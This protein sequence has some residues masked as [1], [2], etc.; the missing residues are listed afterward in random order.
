MLPERADHLATGRGVMRRYTWAL[1]VICCAATLAPV[2]FA[3]D[4]ASPALVAL[5]GLI[6][7]NDEQ[8][9]PIRRARVWAAW[10]DGRADPVFTDDRGRFEIVVRRSGGYSLSVSKPGFA[11]STE[12]REAVDTAEPI[13]IRLTRGAVISGTVRDGNGK[14]V[15]GTGIVVRRTDPSG[16]TYSSGE[17][18]T[19]TDD[20]GEFRVGSLAAGPYA[21][22]VTRPGSQG[23]AGWRSGIFVNAAVDPNLVVHARAGEEQTVHRVFDRPDS[24][25]AGA[26]S[27]VAGFVAGS[28]DPGTPTTAKGGSIAGRVIDAD[29][30]PV[31]AAIVGAF[32]LS[33]ASTH[34]FVEGTFVGTTRTAAASDA[35]GR[36][37]LSGLQPDTYRIVARP[38][39]GRL[40]IPTEGAGAIVTL[41]D[42]ERA[43][44]LDVT[45]PR[46][47]AIAGTVVD[48]FGD[49]IE[50]I[51]VQAW[52]ARWKEGRHVI[53]PAAGAPARKTDD[54]GRYR[55][56]GLAPG[57]Y[58]P[59]VLGDDPPPASPGGRLEIPGSADRSPREI[60][61][62]G[63]ADIREAV[64]VEVLA[65]RDASGIDISR[66]SKPLVRLYGWVVDSSGRPLHGLV[67][68]RANPSSGAPVPAPLVDGVSDGT[69]EFTRV[70]PGDYVLQAVTSD[71][72]EA[73]AA[74]RR[75]IPIEFGMSLVT[76]STDDVGP[77]SM[78][79]AALGGV[80][81]RGRVVAD[82][83]SPG[84]LPAGMAVIAVPAEGGDWPAV[85]RSAARIVEGA[86]EMTG[87]TGAVRFA[88]H[89]APPGWHLESLAIDGVNAVE[90][91][92]TF[93]A[94]LQTRDVEAVLSKAG[95]EISGRVSGTRVS[96]AGAMVLVFPVDR[97]RWYDRSPFLRLATSDSEGRF[98]AAGLPAEEYL[99]VAL[100]AGSVDLMNEW[101]N[102]AVFSALAPSG[103]RVVLEKDGL[104]AV[105]VPLTVRRF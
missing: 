87:L 42:G 54:Q 80:S 55:L 1:A 88:L 39:D 31:A 92:V 68:L 56:Y 7:V 29:G 77:L 61:H 28:R 20:R 38:P 36:Y 3:Q 69:F 53:A 15:A 11:A 51:T 85:S 103:R 57:A 75:E 45:I 58:Y 94:T 48:E 65:A 67:T 60:F 10:T 97:S 13:E 32:P 96:R 84:A 19:D 105:E 22:V 17:Y 70:A 47:S 95:G 49:P 37:Q 71:P 18:V 34:T 90:D 86:F 79:T 4:S 40:E 26:V 78:R 99:V 33:G 62:P 27:F 21:V 2:T 101:G 76:V 63:T 74:Q 50:G 23:S 9:L 35:Q 83:R 82:D 66:P 104:A 5:R 12:F 41:R 100:P 6:V 14:P 98:S 89:G 44:S 73:D 43:A 81:L 30:R 91:P 64:P 24:S 16:T 59:V 46:G 93:G 8:R 52:Q 72:P 102:P 25:V